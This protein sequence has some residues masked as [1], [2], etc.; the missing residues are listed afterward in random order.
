MKKFFLIPISLLTFIL[1]SCDSTKSATN[2]YYDDG[3]YHEPTQSR[4]VATTPANTNDQFSLGSIE[5]PE[6]SITTN[7]NANPEL[8]GNID[9]YDPNDQYY[10]GNGG[11]TVINNYYN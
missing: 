3:I 11:S 10:N 4:P 7:P 8:Y 5:E 6:Q 2:N 9:Y 1:S